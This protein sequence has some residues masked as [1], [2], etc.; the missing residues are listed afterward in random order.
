MIGAHVASCREPVSKMLSLSMT[1]MAVPS[2]DPLAYFSQRL[3]RERRKLSN[4]PDGY[5][6]RP[7]FRQDI[8]SC[9]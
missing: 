3:T 2:C 9:A 6:R 4:R 5:V 8:R 7:V 1:G